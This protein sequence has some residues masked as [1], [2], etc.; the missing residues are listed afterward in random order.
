MRKIRAFCTK[1]K[2]GPLPRLDFPSWGLLPLRIRTLRIR[3][4][5]CYGLPGLRLSACGILSFSRFTLPL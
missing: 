5:G 2:T 4:L 1:N 3:S